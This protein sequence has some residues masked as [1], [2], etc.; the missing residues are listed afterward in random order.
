MTAE[1]IVL[2]QED[3]RVLGYFDYPAN[4]GYYGVF[5]Q[6]AV[7]A[8]QHSHGLEENGQVGMTTG[9]MIQ[10]EAEVKREQLKK[11]AQE[12]AKKQAAEAVKKQ[13]EEA[14]SQSRE[15][16]IETAKQ[17]IGVPYEWGGHSPSGFDCSGFVGYVMEKHKVSLP[18]MS[19]D[20]FQ[21][22]TST[23]SLK[24]G[25]LVFFS[26]Y[27]PGATHVGIYVGNNEFISATSSNGV[28]IDSMDN[29]YWKPRYVGA[30]SVLK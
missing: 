11:Q 19:T 28:K 8:F 20:M 29:S 1:E 12:A 14:V 6:N 9:P 18:R 13:P 5:T 2:L 27:A 16:I 23:S 26:T 15:E 21:S 17:Y 4:S 22:G 7:K 25:D 10:A 3:L 24:A 30:R